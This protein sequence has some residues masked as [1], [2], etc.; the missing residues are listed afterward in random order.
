MHLKI[1]ILN[2]FVV[3][4]IK[5]YLVTEDNQTLTNFEQRFQY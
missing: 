3:V 4:H 1:Y 5:T 2:L